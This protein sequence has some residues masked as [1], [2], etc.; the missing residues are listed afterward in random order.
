M[1][2]AVDELAGEA[3][4]RTAL[5]SLPQATPLLA[6][7]TRIYRLLSKYLVLCEIA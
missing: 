4:L 2:L 6:K 5:S 1:L 7:S 3:M